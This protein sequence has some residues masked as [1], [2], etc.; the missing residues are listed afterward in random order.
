MMPNRSFRIAAVAR[1]FMPGFV[2][3]CLLVGLV[4]PSNS[5]AAR[6]ALLVGSNVAPPGMVP[7]RYAHSDARKMRDVLVELG[8]IKPE[9]A[10]LLLDPTADTLKASL[11]SLRSA[12]MYR[13]LREL[14]GPQSTTATIDGRKVLQFS[15]NNYLG[16][17]DHPRVKAATREAVDM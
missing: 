13:V 7:L 15:S 10:T 16:L 1:L 4:I 6:Q 2:A 9:N 11:E 8:G 17:A 14:R 5:M 3:L 12:G